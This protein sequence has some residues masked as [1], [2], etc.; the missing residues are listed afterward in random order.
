MF[1]ANTYSIRPASQDD[2]DTLRSL[3]ERNGCQPLTG[4]A[5]IGTT[6]AG[7]VAAI[8]LEDG[9][10]IS[11]P[12]TDHLLANLRTRAAAA[13]A[14]EVTPA[15]RDRMLAGLPAWLQA[16]STPIA[17]PATADTEPQPAL[18]TA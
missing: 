7:A 18:A 2:T 16:V 3:A 4:P 9:R 11:D 8:S 12:H 15:T 13:A 10:T 6:P 17:Q 5:L 14:Y 1:A